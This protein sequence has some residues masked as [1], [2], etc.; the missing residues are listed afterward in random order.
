MP[1]SRMIVVNIINKMSKETEEDF[2]LIGSTPSGTFQAFISVLKQSVINW[3][4]GVMAIT[5]DFE[6]NNPSSNLGRT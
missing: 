6:S 2:V 5:L 1:F 3:F 4:Y